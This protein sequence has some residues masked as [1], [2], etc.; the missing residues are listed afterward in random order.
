MHLLTSCGMP[1][2]TS[3]RQSRGAV[4]GGESTIISAPSARKYSIVLGVNCYANLAL[5]L[6]LVT[7]GLT[8]CASTSRKSWDEASQAVKA[9]RS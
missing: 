1:Q 7:T 2:V 6:L 8:G 9:A 3:G 4:V 5:V